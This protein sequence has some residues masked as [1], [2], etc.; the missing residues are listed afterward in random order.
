M[1]R[2]VAVKNRRL[3]EVILDWELEEFVEEAKAG[4]FNPRG[5]DR[6]WR[7]EPRRAGE[8]TTEWRGGR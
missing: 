4:R 1:D 8:L 2:G 7:R 6:T 5:G 3:S